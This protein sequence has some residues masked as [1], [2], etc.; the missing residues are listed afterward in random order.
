MKD[1]LKELC[2]NLNIKLIY[3]NDDN[4]ALSSGIDEAGLFIKTNHIF[5]RCP[6]RIAKAIIWYYT[7]PRYESDCLKKITDYLNDNVV[8][9]EYTIQSPDK[10]FKEMLGHIEK[11]EPMTGGTLKKAESDSKSSKDNKSTRN[12]SSCKTS[13]EDQSFVELNISSITKKN[14]YGSVF[15]INPDEAI[16]ASNDDIVELDIQVDDSEI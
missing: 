7:D 16:S 9:A 12:T 5:I 8:A 4:I 11:K 15:N 3:S 13:G 2:D 6:E 10:N 14:F 1:Y